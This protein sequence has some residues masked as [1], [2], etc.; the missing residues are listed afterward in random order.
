MFKL[1]PGSQYDAGAYVC[2]L[3]SGTTRLEPGSIRVLPDNKLQPHTVN[4]AC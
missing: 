2:T 3:A 1:K 4:K